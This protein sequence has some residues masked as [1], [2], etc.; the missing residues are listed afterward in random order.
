MDANSPYVGSTV[1]R[2]GQKN[3]RGVGWRECGRVRAHPA[4]SCPGRAPHLE[5][6][7]K[8]EAEE[9]LG[10]TRRKGTDWPAKSDL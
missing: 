8:G 7:L 2:G 4:D 10:E 6:D 3:K 9:V 5:V 1:L